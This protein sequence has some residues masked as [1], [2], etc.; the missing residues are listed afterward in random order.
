MSTEAINIDTSTPETPEVLSQEGSEDTLRVTYDSADVTPE[1]APSETTPSDDRPEWLPEK[2]S[3]AED[4]AK[5]YAELEKKQGAAPEAKPEDE[6]TATADRKPIEDTNPIEGEFSVES[7]QDKWAEQGG[8]LSD[9]Q[10]SEIQKNTGIPM[11]TL[12]AYEK[13]MVSQHQETVVS[14]DQKIFDVAGGEDSYNVMIEWANDKLNQDQIDSLNTQLD[15]PQFS[16]MGMKM[17]KGLY[18]QSNGHEAS[19]VVANKATSSVIGSD[20]FQS[21]GEV[22]EAMAHP[23]YG[24]DG[25]YDR[26]FDQKLMRYMKRTGQM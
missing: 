13:S 1:A 8:Q 15:N 21:E 4:M 18:E 23:E 25:K 6:P 14:N 2:F 9:E 20:E 16:E 11:E 7:Y 24:K 26:E 5:A 12:R 19:I 17:L 3:S 22:Q 10:W